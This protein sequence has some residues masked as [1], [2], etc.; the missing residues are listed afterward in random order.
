MCPVKG[1][2]AVHAKDG[3]V[4]Y[5]AEA[6]RG[7]L[8]AIRDAAIVQGIE[9]DEAKLLPSPFSGLLADDIPDGL[10]TADF[11]LDDGQREC[12]AA[13]LREAI[14]INHASVNAGKTFMFATAAAFIKRR[15]TDSRVLYFTQSERLVRQAFKEMRKFLPDWNITQFGGG[16]RDNSGKDM[17]VA[18]G[19]V[20]NR[21]FDVLKRDGWFKSFMTVLCDE[22]QHAGSPSMQKVLRVIPAFFRF[23]ASDTMLEDDIVKNTAI[24]GVLG[25]QLDY[26]IQAGELIDMGR[27]ARPHIYVVDDRT[28]EG[29]FMH[30]EHSAKEGT[31]AWCLVD[32]RWEKATYLGPAYE[33]DSEAVDGIKLNADGSIITIPNMQRVVLDSDKTEREIE[34][35][36]CL[37]ERLGDQAIVR[38]GERNKLIAMWAKF[39]SDSKWPT[40]VVCTRTLH[41]LILQAVISEQV[42]PELVRIL[43]GSHSSKER[44]VAFKWLKSTPG[45]VLI[46]PLVKEGVSINEIKAGIIADHVVNW[47]VAEQLLG[48]F[49]RK[50]LDGPNVAHVTMFIDR[51]HN[52]YRRA[53]IQLLKKLETI[54]GY[55]YHYP[56]IDPGS[57]DAAKEHGRA[58]CT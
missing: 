10:V 30:L 39:Y 53:S 7:H 29:R 50:K 43:Y 48:R 19:A 49:V 58:T 32:G 47:E 54:R 44:D 3:S 11:V 36:W 9:L 1:K 42:S 18:T 37:L 38:F 57:I 8:D 24:R 34:S 4:C 51:Q 22:S 55:I 56:V 6:L 52:K 23:G 17:V 28:W 31:S 14:G 35:R 25:P 12:V 46:T 40:V 21:N 41:V 45:S 33:T 16:A 13:W 15:F 26:E 20:M 27:S 5:T 2:G